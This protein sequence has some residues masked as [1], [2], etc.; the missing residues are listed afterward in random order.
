MKEAK[1]MPSSAKCITIHLKR[2]LHPREIVR[3]RGN[4]ERL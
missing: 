2:D 3:P 1:L 4:E